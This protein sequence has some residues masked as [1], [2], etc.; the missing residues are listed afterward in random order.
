MLT[1]TL[2]PTFERM[3]TL[4]RE[5]DRAFAASWTGPRSF[6]PALDVVEK[7]SG[8]TISAEL[9]GVEPSSVEILF[10]QNMLTIRGSK[11]AAIET[12]EKG[13]VRS[14]LAER[15]SGSFARTVRLP[16]FVDADKITAS[17]TNGVLTITVPK[18]TAALKR[19]IT[20]GVQSN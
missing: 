19:K 13:D 1:R 12:P 20:I 3:M 2:L 11:P 18:S 8:Y 17:F 14:Y 7:E 10:E 9:P 15:T 16:D 4:N 6:V 5:L